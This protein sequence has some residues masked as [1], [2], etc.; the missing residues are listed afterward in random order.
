MMKILNSNHASK[1]TT[2]ELL[3]SVNGAETYTTSYGNYSLR[4]P[5]SNIGN[6]QNVIIERTIYE[7][8]IPNN[9][10]NIIMW[11]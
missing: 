6:V 7:I 10:C 4:Y 1:I 11:V 2:I 9:V 5:N 3:G 8:F